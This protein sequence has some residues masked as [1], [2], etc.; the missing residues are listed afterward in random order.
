MK[1]RTKNLACLAAF[2]ILLT[3]SQVAS[4]RNTE[5]SNYDL[6]WNTPSKDASG[7]MPIGNGEVGA[8]V[9]VEPNGDLVF[10]IS[11]TDSW[12]ET[13]E[14]YK[15]GRIR[16]SF[17]PSIVSQG[18]FC[19][20]LDLADGR[21]R[22]QGAGTDLSFWIDSEQPVIRIAGNS[23]NGV[24]ITAKA[25]I[26]RD[27]QERITQ[28][29]AQRFCRSISGFPDD[30]IFNR[31]PDEILDSKDAVTV[32]HHNICSSYDATLDLESI[33][34][35]NRAAYDPFKDRCFG[36]KME[37]KDLS[38]AS[39]LKLTSNGAIKDIDLRIITNSG[40]YSNP[41]DWTAKVND[42]ASD[43]PACGKSLRRTAKYWNR[44]WDK[45]YIFVETPDGETG[46]KITSSYIL[47][48]WVQACAGR[49][50]YPIKFNGTIFTVDSKYT[51]S[52]TDEDPDYRRWGGDYWWQNTRLVY[53]PMLKSGDYDM[54]KVVFEHYFRNL[55]MMK[56]LARALLGAEGAISPETATVFGTYCPQDY[57]WDRS[58][59]TDL[60]TINQYVKRYWSSSLEMIS[61][62]LD[63][64]DYTGDKSFARDRI[65]P[66]AKEFLTFYDTQYG[67]DANGKLRIDPTQS[68][69]TYWYDVVNDMP[70]VAG[71]NDVLPRLQALPSELS[72]E[73]NK[74]LWK[75]LADALPDLPTKMDNGVKVFSP[76]DS[77]NPQRSNFENPELYAIFPFHLCNISTDN[78]EMGRESYARRII[79]G[80]VG[81]SQ[82]G[83]EAARIGLTK[84]ATED[85]I[86]KTQNSNPSFRFPAY[87]GP[88]FD[89]TP[90][91]DHGSNL[92]I[93]LQDMVLQTYNGKDYILPAFPDDWGVK[94]K[95]HSFN[96]KK[97]KYERPLQ[98]LS[99]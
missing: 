52:E 86:A 25:E 99:K 68:L 63:Y 10:Y 76:A 12:S 40:I 56:A 58:N 88:N 17:N 47:Q 7:S 37:G 71:L 19:Q 14:L 22:L 34:I 79:K 74:T 65:I 94:F 80:H 32:R 11:R 64:Y 67:H 46:R 72:D 6:V 77:Y 82:D 98:K 21:I 1:T 15:L 60:L 41:N 35:E 38:K 59:C 5:V 2:A 66:Y 92:L 97:V 18:D 8:N 3:M 49:G 42:I 31:Y 45:S 93:T 78:V 36:F 23:K 70:T 26:W 53:H 62:M 85:L 87:W 73:A 55:P 4:A 89:W 75:H 44:Y 51:A 91:Q 20:R 30:V 95:L 33:K 90:D 13:G 69:E 83:Q 16:V 9:W 57:G 48:T 81:W 50:N 43:S 24:S 54:M 29:M 84:E 39:K 96:G 61:L 28:E 27:R